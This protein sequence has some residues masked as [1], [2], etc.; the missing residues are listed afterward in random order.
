MMFPVGSNNVSEDISKSANYLLKRRKS[1]F[2]PRTNAYIK[3]RGRKET[4]FEFT[5]ISMAV[6][7]LY[8]R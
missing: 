3:H 4:P 5:V 7:Y 8:N 1:L 6:S 2:D